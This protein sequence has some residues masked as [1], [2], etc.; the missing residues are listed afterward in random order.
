[1]DTSC[2]IGPLSY[3]TNVFNFQCHNQMRHWS[4]HITWKRYWEK[5]GN[6]IE[7]GREMTT[8]A[9]ITLSLAGR[10][11][12]HLENVSYGQ[13][14]ASASS[15]GTCQALHWWHGGWW[16]PAPSADLAVTWPRS[17]ACQSRRPPQFCTSWGESSLFSCLK[18]R[19]ALGFPKSWTAASSK[20]LRPPLSPWDDPAEL[21][22]VWHKQLKFFTGLDQQEEALQTSLVQ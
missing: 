22:L 18:D 19:N 5:R 13:T 1:M 4:C 20:K 15:L 12:E 8:P 16:S 11:S 3:S 17:M 10:Y 21:Q 14:S 7:I 6:N 9:C 2:W